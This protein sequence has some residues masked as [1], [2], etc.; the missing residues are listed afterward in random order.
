M[1]IVDVATKRDYHV[2]DCIARDH[3][4]RGLAIP[5]AKPKPPA[6]NP[7]TDWVAKKGPIV[8]NTLYPP[9][10]VAHCK[11]CG[12]KFTAEGPNSAENGLFLHC[13]IQEEI[14]DYIRNEYMRLRKAYMD[15][16]KRG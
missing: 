9:M 10:I 3:I 16:A 5:Y 1:R 14:P 2:P 12:L 6:P 7:R 8:G 13:R 4:T 11:S 15:W